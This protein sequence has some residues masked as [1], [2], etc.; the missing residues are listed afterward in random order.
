M[1]AIVHNRLHQVWFVCFCVWVAMSMTSMALMSIGSAL[2]FLPTL[3]AL[4]YS[5]QRADTGY[6]LHNLFFYAS[7]ALFFVATLSIVAGQVWPP[8][9]MHTD[10]LQ[11]LKKLR[12]FLFPFATAFLFANLREIPDFQHRF[13]RVLFAMALLVSGIAIFQFFAGAVFGEAFIEG[14]RFFRQIAATPYSHAQGLMYFHLSFASVMGFVFCFAFAHTIWHKKRRLIWL[15]ISLIT[16]LAWFFTYSRISMAACFFAVLC[17]LG[18]RKPKLGAIG[19]LLIV[20]GAAVAWQQSDALRKRVLDKGGWRDREVVWASAMEMIADRPLLGV[21]FNQTGFYSAHYARRYYDRPE[22]AMAKRIN[23]IHYYPQKDWFSSHSHNNILDAMAAMGIPGLL[24]YLFWWGTLFY[25]AIR[26]YFDVKY[27][28]LAAALLTGGL[29]F[30]ING[31]TQ[32]NFYDGKSQHML[33]LWAGILVTLYFHRFA[34]A[35]TNQSKK[36]A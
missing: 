16:G 13:W 23:E 35:K 1:S 8:L 4:F 25:Y 29:V 26:L 19:L 21:G 36:K 22:N 28:S 27:Q 34:N 31:L 14:K 30:Q 5:D 17:L 12:Y 24:A 33:M 32:L 18:L 10:S 2:F 20:I 7:V 3:V 9:E 15:A 6:L 11:N